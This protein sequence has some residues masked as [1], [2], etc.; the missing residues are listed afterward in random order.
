MKTMYL[1]KGEYTKTGKIFYLGKGGYVVNYEGGYC[2]YMDCY[3]TERAAKMTA[4]KYNKRNEFDV[5]HN[6]KYISE[7]HYSA[8]PVEF[9][10][11]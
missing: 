4:T 3:E 11:V 7:T 6:S 5:K 10:T 1:I 2:F 8:F 9:G